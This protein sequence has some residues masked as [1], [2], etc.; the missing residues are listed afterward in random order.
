[1]PLLLPPPELQFCDADGMPFA[2]G[3][4]NFYIPGTDS[5]KDTWSNHEGT[6]LNTN[7]VVLDAAGRAII[8]G[9]GEYRAVLRDAA[10][11]L[12]WDQ[13]TSSVISAAMMPVVQAPTIAEARRLLGIDDAIQAEIDRAEAAEAA[14]RNDLNAEIA[15]AEAAEASL[16]ADL[17][18]E[19]AR[20]EAAEA[21]LNSRMDGIQTCIGG[22]D[23]T[24]GG[25]ASVTFATAFASGTTPVVVATP[26]GTTL[27][28]VS[29][30]IGNVTN[31]GFQC[32]LAF[33]LTSGPTSAGT[34]G[35]HWIALGTPA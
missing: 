33:P 32:W 16:R 25:V 1:M 11:N 21:A 5:P 27:D 31:T 14:L 4:I 2:A 24:S 13:W 29:P 34:R 19:I 7:P 10:G 30:T 3:T 12:I 6:T 17:N 23:Y 35:F 9:D 8:F 28:I 18:A 15:R 20:A 26:L 22:L